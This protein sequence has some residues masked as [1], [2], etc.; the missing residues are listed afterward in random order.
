MS[1][2]SEEKGD[3]TN[4]VSNESIKLVFAGEETALTRDIAAKRAEAA[5]KRDDAV[6]KRASAGEKRR[7][8]GNEGPEAEGDN[9]NH[10]NR[11]GLRWQVEELKA[12]IVT[13]DAT[14]EAKKNAYTTSLVTLVGTPQGEAKAK[15][16]EY[17]TT[18]AA[19]MEG[20]EG[21][22]CAGCGVRALGHAPRPY[23][24]ERSVI[25]M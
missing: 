23:S 10:D 8:A 12:T 18:A 5:T 2:A 17:L 21:G 1:Q 20:G 4:L 13:L 19:A 6:S 24:S 25:T 22:R 9:E 14:S 7:A 15:A 3:D 16:N 11:Q